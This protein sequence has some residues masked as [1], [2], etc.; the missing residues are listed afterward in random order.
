MTL[1]CE[2]RCDFH[3]SGCLNEKAWPMAGFVMKRSAAIAAWDL[4]RTQGEALGWKITR[5]GTVSCPN[6]RKRK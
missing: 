2:L 1:W 4:L 6:C 5:D 3:L